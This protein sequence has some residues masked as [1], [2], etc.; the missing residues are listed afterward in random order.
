M[1][2]IESLDT[3]IVKQIIDRSAALKTDSAEKTA[4]A[5]ETLFS[6]YSGQFRI[7]SCDGQEIAPALFF[8]FREKRE[9]DR[10]VTNVYI[11]RDPAP[12]KK[13]SP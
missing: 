1:Q 5:D 9:A 8:V 13:F 7:H 12:L 11:E 3:G 6:R 2:E 4:R 10:S